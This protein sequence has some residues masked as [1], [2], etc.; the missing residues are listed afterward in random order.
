M[1]YCSVIFLVK[2][3]ENSE[4][5]RICGTY[6]TPFF[7]QRLYDMMAPF[8]MQ[9]I[10]LYDEQHMHKVSKTSFRSINVIRNATEIA[11]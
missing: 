7:I 8:V 9:L 6:G 3:V 10:G 11:Q 4:I 5:G 1:S 2:I